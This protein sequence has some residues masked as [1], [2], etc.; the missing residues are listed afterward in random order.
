[1]H[2][3]RCFICSARDFP[4]SCFLELT[5]IKR[6]AILFAGTKLSPKNRFLNLESERLFIFLD[7]DLTPCYLPEPFPK[8][9]N[10]FVESLDGIASLNAVD[11]L[12]PQRYICFYSGREPFCLGNL[13]FD[14]RTLWPLPLR[15]AN[16]SAREMRPRSAATSYA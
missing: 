16:V 14:E 10:K 7:I 8:N 1:M 4:R 3:R 13:R 12:I 5:R 15:E 2:I 11:W 6:I 9:R